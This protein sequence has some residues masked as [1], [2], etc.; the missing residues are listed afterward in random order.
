[1]PNSV[2]KVSCRD[3]GVYKGF[4][5]V[6]SVSYACFPVARAQPNTL[7]EQHVYTLCFIMP[8]RCFFCF[9]FQAL[10]GLM[11]VPSSPFSPHSS[12]CIPPT[13]QIS[14]Q[15][16]RQTQY[17]LHKLSF[18]ESKEGGGGLCLG[19]LLLA[20][21]NGSHW[22]DLVNDSKRISPAESGNIL[23]YT[24]ANLPSQVL[25]LKRMYSLFLL[26]SV[27]SAFWIEEMGTAQ[28]PQ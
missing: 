6:R 23:C 10:S 5:T 1:M 14:G 25:F 13:P 24:Y 16:P 21:E 8:R 19:F 27:N 17:R 11:F 3:S 12:P 4:H 18:L 15:L 7:W 26:S 20:T 22:T 2:I 9:I 28:R